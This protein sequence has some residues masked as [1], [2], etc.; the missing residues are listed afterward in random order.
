MGSRVVVAALLAIASDYLIVRNCQHNIGR[1][2]WLVLASAVTAAVMAL[3]I[4]DV[5]RWLPGGVTT[6]KFDSLAVLPFANLSGSAE[7]DYLAE[8]MHE[9]LIPDLAKLGG[10]RRVTARASVMSCRKTDMPVQQIARELGVNA[11]MTG[12]VQGDG[13]HVRI[14]AQLIKVAT[15][16]QM[17]ADRYERDLRDVLTMQGEI[18]TAITRELKIQLTPNDRARLASARPVNPEAHEAYLKGKF[19]VHKL[20]PEGVEKGLAYYRQAIEK[21]PSHPL[22][23][24]MLAMAYDLLGHSDRP[25]PDAFQLAKAAALKALELDETL[26]EAHEAM[27][28]VKLFSEWGDWAGI[29]QAFRRSIELN[30]NLAEAHRTY[31]WALL[32]TGDAQAIPEM[33]RAQELDPLTPLWTADL[34]YQYWTLGQYGKGIEEARKSA[35]LAP[36]FAYGYWVLDEIYADA[37]PYSEAIAA[38]QKATALDPAWKWTLGRAY[39][40]SGRKDQARKIAAEIAKDP[41]PIHTWGLAELHAAL[42][43]KDEALRW[44]EEAYKVRWGWMPWIHRIPALK[45][46]R[47]EP[48][49][50]EL[51]RRMN[52]PVPGRTAALP[53]NRHSAHPIS[54]LASCTCP[55]SII[56]STSCRWNHW[57]SIRS[58]SIGAAGPAVNSCAT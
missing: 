38:S 10:L 30:P 56:V 46:L 48:R 7:Q 52:L 57:H 8:G 26:A 23:Y 25:P 13:G 15:G 58:S 21:D 36:G 37:G 35:E 16:A 47:G 2:R 12:A 5:R 33:R 34:A 17:W 43:D 18:V 51:E 32:L 14:T 49:F 20:T 53:R 54:V 4:G 40:L 45:S 27:A 41:L 9:A 42:G 22:P 1:R 29:I 6:A 50:Q 24:A 31:S 39:A 44:L 3:N 28:E 55:F 19:Y 11:I